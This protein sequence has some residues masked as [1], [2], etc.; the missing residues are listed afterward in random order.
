[1]QQEIG[2]RYETIGRC[3]YSKFAPF[4]YSQYLPNHF[5]YIQNSLLVPEHKKCI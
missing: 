5:V 4:P 1:M 3:K 2:H